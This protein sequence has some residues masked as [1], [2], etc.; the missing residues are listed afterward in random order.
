M[1]DIFCPEGASLIPLGGN[2][3]AGLFAIVDSG[4]YEWLSQY[5]WHVV[6]RNY[7]RTNIDGRGVLMHRLV[8]GAPKGS[9]VDHI[10]H[11]PLDNRRSNLR[12]CTQRE[13]MKNALP[14]SKGKETSRYKGVQRVCEGKYSAVINHD[15]KRYNLGRYADEVAAARAYDA[16][17]RYFS[18]E[19][20]LTNFPGTEALPPLEIRHQTKTNLTSKFPG[21]C[22]YARTGK[23]QAFLGKRYLG[24]F[25]TE[26]EAH[27]ARLIAEKSQ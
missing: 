19:F 17:A 22:L 13:N 5:Y 15:G 24:T 23:W 25:A 4:D 9:V 26:E 1:S 6:A 2:K 14:R 20:A 27:E 16:A 21:V 11:N 12:L 18:P 8:L 7:V 3:A 10:N